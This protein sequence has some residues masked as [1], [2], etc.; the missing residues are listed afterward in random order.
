MGAIAGTCSEGV[1]LMIRSG[2]KA[3]AAAGN[4]VNARMTQVSTSTRTDDDPELRMALLGRGGRALN[5][6]MDAAAEQ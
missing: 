2:S 6:E 1:G 3:L 4:A 5:A